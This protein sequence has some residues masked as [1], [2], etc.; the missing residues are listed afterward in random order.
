MYIGAWQ[1]YRLA[2]AFTQPSDH[3]HAQ[4]TEFYG[5]WQKLCDE[6]GEAAATK[7]LIFDP[8]FASVAGQQEQ[9]QQQQTKQACYQLQQEPATSSSSSASGRKWRLGN[10]NGNNTGSTMTS[11]ALGGIR[12]KSAGSNNNSRV[13]SRGQQ[14]V[15]QGVRTVQKRKENYMIQMRDMSD[16]ARSS[17][18]GTKT[19]RGAR[20]VYPER[21]ERENVPPT[22]S[23]STSSATTSERVLTANPNRYVAASQID[24]AATKDIETGPA[25]H[26]TYGATTLRTSTVTT[27]SQLQQQQHVYQE[28]QYQPQ[29]QQQPQQLQQQQQQQPQQ[30]QQQQQQHFPPQQYQRQQPTTDLPRAPPL[31]QPQ[32]VTIPNSLSSPIR[33]NT[34]FTTHTPQSVTSMSSP[35]VWEEEV[36]E[37]LKWTEGLEDDNDPLDMSFSEGM[38]FASSSPPPQ[39]KVPSR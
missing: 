16:G 25:T 7:A 13:R 38:N 33:V 11:A 9:Q 3:R 8:L 22:F 37:L 14:F 2:N 19:I 34:Q 31:Q 32:R 1:E 17:P 6:Q 29:Y 30:L 12:G 21:N 23:Y 36:D 15:R 4:L 27:G 20:R 10:G 18:G 5:T 28:Q 26:I 39:E 35:H 24:T